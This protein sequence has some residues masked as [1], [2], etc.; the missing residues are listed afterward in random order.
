MPFKF[1]Y[2]RWCNVLDLTNLSI[3]ITKYKIV[4]ENYDDVVESTQGSVEV[5]TTWIT[6]IRHFCQ[7]LDKY[8]SSKIFSAIRHFFAKISEIQA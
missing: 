2:Q 5:M 1:G 7:F 6:I 3:K 4:D 8:Q